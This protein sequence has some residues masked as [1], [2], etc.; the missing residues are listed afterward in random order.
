MKFQA[1]TTAAVQDQRIRTRLQAAIAGNVKRG[2]G[3]KSFADVVDAEFDKAGL[4]RLKSYQIDNI[5]VTNTSLAYGSGQMSK[6]LEVSSDFPFW[7]YS[8]TMDSRTRPDHAALHGKIFRTGDFTFFPPIGFRCRCTAIPLT[9]RQAAKYLKSAM[10][11]EMEKKLIHDRLTSKEFVG[12]KQQKYLEWVADQYEKSDAETR[13]LMDDAFDRMKAEIKAAKPDE[14]PEKGS[15][16]ATPKPDDQAWIPA[17]LHADGEYLRGTGIRFKKEFFDL[18]D[19]EHPIRLALEK[20][21]KGSYYLPSEKTVHIANSKRVSASNW[22]KQSVIYHEFGH[23]IDWQRGLRTTQEIDKLMRSWRKE[24][25]KEQEYTFRRGGKKAVRKLP[26]LEYLSYQ[27]D[28]I[29]IRIQKMDDATLAKRGI[30]KSDLVEQVASTQDTIMAINPNYGWGH[31]KAYYKHAGLRQ[32]EFIAHCFENAFAGN[33]VFKKYLPELYEAMVG[34][35][36][37]LK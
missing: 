23:A 18:I 27:L 5:Y 25:M 32:A 33:T 36:K 29:R 35:I 13:K 9:S 10:P 26:R 20:S 7:K 2:E 6:M 8:A 34:F 12:N 11:D 3:A 24:L 17:E 31:T 30:T 19:K 1:F 14:K 21:N 37:D 28:A 22:F 16:K 4:T 15:L